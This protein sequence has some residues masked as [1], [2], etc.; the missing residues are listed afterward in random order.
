[1]MSDTLKILVSQQKS[2]FSYEKKKKD[3]DTVVGL[4][5]LAEGTNLVT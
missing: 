5:D 4:N 2:T 1:M 3:E